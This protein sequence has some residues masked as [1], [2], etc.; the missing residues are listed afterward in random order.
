MTYTQPPP[1]AL[2]NEKVLEACWEICIIKPLK[3]TKLEMA[4]AFLTL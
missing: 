3:E 1:G 2:P 4:W